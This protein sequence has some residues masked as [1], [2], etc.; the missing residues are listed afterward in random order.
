MQSGVI[1][2]DHASEGWTRYE[3]NQDSCLAEAGRLN[4][5]LILAALNC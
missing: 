1:I 5:E 4:V 2:D 3:R